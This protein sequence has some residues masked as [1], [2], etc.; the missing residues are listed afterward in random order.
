MNARDWTAEL[1]AY[2]DGELEEADAKAL[3]AQLATD[4]ALKAQEQQLRRTVALMAKVPQVEPS[5]DLRRAVLNGLDT[6]PSFG[7]RLMAW[8]TPARLVPAAALLTAAV[9]TVVM[10]RGGAG[11][12]LPQGVPVEDE[13]LLIAQNMEVLEDLDLVDL[14]TADDLDVVASLH[15][16]EVQ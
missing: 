1:T 14:D 13:Q 11:E 9:V 10:V 5:A 3:E 8:L 12:K 7:E 2:I 15:E 4:P 6:A 16:L